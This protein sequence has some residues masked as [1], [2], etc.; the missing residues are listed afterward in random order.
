[1]KKN[2]SYIINIILVLVIVA[3]SWPRVTTDL[4]KSQSSDVKDVYPCGKVILSPEDEYVGLTV[5]WVAIPHTDFKLV[6]N[7]SEESWDFIIKDEDGKWVTTRDFDKGI[8]IAQDSDVKM[9]VECDGSWYDSQFID[10][11]TFEEPIRLPSIDGSSTNIEYLHKQLYVKLPGSWYCKYRWDDGNYYDYQTGKIKVK[12]EL[13]YIEYYSTVL[14]KN[15]AIEATWT[16]GRITGYTVS[17][18]EY[19]T[20]PGTSGVCSDQE[21]G[22]IPFTYKTVYFS[23]G[24]EPSTD[25]IMHLVYGEDQN[26]VLQETEDILASSIYEGVWTWQTDEYDWKYGNWILEEGSLVPYN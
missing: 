20:N 15:V 26:A 2:L 6:W 4:M 3:I 11:K 16:D 7:E 22:W 1:M 10:T 23:C 25:A 21:K 24:K 13:A 8:T 9:K 18:V 14:E 19:V 5:R 17:V 12:C